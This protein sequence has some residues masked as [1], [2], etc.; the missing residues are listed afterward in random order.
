VKRAPAKIPVADEQIE[1]A[2]DEVRR[3]VV[4]LTS[5]PFLSGVDVDVT[6]PDGLLVEVRHG[7]G[8]RF[9]GYSLSAPMGAATAGLIAE[10]APARDRAAVRLTATGFGATVTLRMRVW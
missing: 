10:S 3:S 5:D 9:V 7:L 4:E 2:I 1:R 8:R 6:L